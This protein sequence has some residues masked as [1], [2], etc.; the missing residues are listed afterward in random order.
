MNTDEIIYSFSEL[1]KILFNYL[2]GNKDKY[3]DII[4]NAIIKAE[5]ENPWF[6]KQFII[7]RLNVIKSYLEP[8]SLQNWISNYPEIKSQEKNKTLTIGV[9]N[10]GNIPLVG[11]HDFLCVLITGNKYYVKLSSKDSELFKLIFT[12]L[13]DINPELTPYIQVENDILKNFDVI[14]ATGSN[15]TSR[16]FEYYFGRYPNI[17]RNNKN[18][19]A[20]LDGTETEEMLKKLA[21]D[22]FLYFGLGCRNVSKIYLPE[23]INI[24]EILTHFNKYESFINHNKYVNNYEYNR[25]IYLLN[26]EEHLDTG[27]ALFKKSDQ[28][29][30]P[31]SVVYFD[32]YK[33]IHNL[34]NEISSISG[35]LQCIATQ[36]D[37]FKNRIDF[38]NTQ[39][40]DL[41]DYADG[42]DTIEFLLSLK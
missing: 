32:Y 1:G 12:I 39:M 24:N 33:K 23:N 25:A 16:Y 10:A 21:D 2:S 38:G 13:I 9:V 35:S 19:I 22:I 6:T 36:I 34:Y 42:I 30:P 31:I 28:I 15:N 26:K 41:T 37:I 14:I 3:T 40:P 17:I 7:H 20:I 4:S 29:F 5:A 11:F 18:S 27:F 8:E